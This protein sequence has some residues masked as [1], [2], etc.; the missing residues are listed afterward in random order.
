MLLP[1]QMSSSLKNCDTLPLEMMPLPAGPA[2]TPV[3]SVAI[4]LMISG[5][6]LTGGVV[7]SGSSTPACSSAGQVEVFPGRLIGGQ[8]LERRRGRAVGEDRRPQLRRPARSTAPR[9]RRG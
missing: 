2:S 8:V 7:P 9:T 4:T 1:Y 5:F 3:A 6:W